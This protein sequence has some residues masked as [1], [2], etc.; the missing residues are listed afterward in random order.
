MDPRDPV[1]LANPERT[2]RCPLC[3]VPQRILPGSF[4]AALSY[5]VKT[6]FCFPKMY[7]VFRKT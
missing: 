4:V 2:H 5:M 1:R 6:N 3:H 7:F